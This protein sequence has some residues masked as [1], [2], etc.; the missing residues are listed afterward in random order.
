[1]MVCCILI[2]LVWGFIINDING[3]SFFSSNSADK[4]PVNTDKALEIRKECY[5]LLDEGRN[6]D[7]ISYV[8]SKGYTVYGETFVNTIFIQENLL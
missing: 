5:R 8:C 3:F 1:M 4:Y 6:L 2:L 7:L